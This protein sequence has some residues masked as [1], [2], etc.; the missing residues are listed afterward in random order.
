MQTMRALARRRCG[1][2]PMPRGEET[3]AQPCA[4]A[5][6]D[7]DNDDLEENEE[8]DEE[9]DNDDEDLFVSTAMH[10]LAVHRHRTSPA[11]VL[12]PRAGSPKCSTTR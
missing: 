1:A 10:S 9:G 2:S 4:D 7:D 11:E 12:E 5:L 8:N 3:A 6:D